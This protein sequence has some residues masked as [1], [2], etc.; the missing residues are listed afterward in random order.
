M[1]NI[2]QEI[3]KAFYKHPDQFISGETLSQTCHCTRAA[4]WKHIEELRQEGYQFE[5]LRK[6]G[7]RLTYSPDILT[8]EEI[9]AGMKT[10]RIGQQIIAYDAVQSTQL[11][12]HEAAAKGAAEGTL[13][14]AD[15]QLGGKGRLG[16]PWHSP[17]GTGIWMSMILRP[18][19]P[20]PKAPQL[21]LLTAV[22][23]N[24]A[25]RS[26]T[27]VPV[28][29]KWPN[30]LLVGGKKLCGI[31]T[32]LNAESDRINYLVIGIGLNVNMERS[33]FPHELGDI[34]TSLRIESGRSWRRSMLIQA[35]CAHFE[36]EYDHY[37]AQGFSQV[38]SR[39]E[40]HA[41]S[42]G[43]TVTVRTI[44]NTITGKAM[45]L[46]ADGVLI[47]EDEAGVRHKVY[48]ADVDFNANR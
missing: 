31:L 5:A 19:I 8:A 28:Q 37:L 11:L 7:Y 34:P 39:W 12:A 30:D 22:A 13:L 6:A 35:F 18:V 2:K 16:R 26:V 36:E 27:G 41:M 45:G 32:E 4:V 42:L 33:D 40:E 48:S 17:K 46:D 3:L 15:Q 24:R 21:T 9:R 47:V 20:L 25:L 1:K 14:V 10:E 43:R 38:K 44:H 29:I 23:L